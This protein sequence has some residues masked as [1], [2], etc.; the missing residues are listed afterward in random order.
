MRGLFQESKALSAVSITLTELI[1][2]V[3]KKREEI[4]EIFDFNKNKI[5]CKDFW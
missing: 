1:E 4:G 5:T 3:I 2:I